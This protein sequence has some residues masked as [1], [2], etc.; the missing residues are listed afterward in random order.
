MVC[1]LFGHRDANS[2]I[3]DKLQEAIS[4][5]FNQ[6]KSI[7]FYVGNNGSFDFFA[8]KILD[9]MSQTQNL[10]YTIFLSKINEAALNG[11]QERTVFLEEVE[12]APYRFAI[13]RRNLC[14]LNRADI[15]ITFVATKFSNSYKLMEKAKKRGLTVI[16]LAQT[17]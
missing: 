11:K 9:D 5:I 1:V 7:E 13:D 10:N 3:F 2:K 12:K 16:N 8:Q 14:M 4:A 6:N 17:E 15:L